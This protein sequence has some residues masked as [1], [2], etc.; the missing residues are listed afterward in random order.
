MNLV[1]SPLDWFILL[2][3][4]LGSL[5]FGM[6]MAYRKNS[7]KDS[8]SFF[9]GGRSIK[10]PVIGASLFA[11][12]IG[13]EH[14]VGLSGDSYRY[15]LSAG[16]VELTTV[17]TL[18]V[19]CAI[20]FPYY[21]KNKLF[22]IPE[23][24][25]LRYNRRTR[26]FFSGLML[27]ISIMTKL[28]FTLFAGALVLNSLLG[29]NIMSTI[30]YIGLAV[31][32]F[33]IIGGFTAVAYTDALQVLII[34]GGAAIMMFIGLDK[35]G[36][37]TGLMEKAPQ[38]MSIAK[39]YDDPVYPFWGILATAFY[40]GIFYWGM[41]QV[42][43]QRTLAA[44]D[45]KNARWGAMFATLLKLLPVFIFALPGVI[46]F[47][48]FPGELQGDETKQTFVLL[49]NKLLPSGLRGLLMA[50]LLAAMI[51]SLIGVLNSV[52]TLVVRDFIVEFKPDFPEKKQVSLGR[53]VILAVTLLG[54]GAAYMVYKNEEGLYKYL[55]TISAY[56]V[57]PVFP[58]ILFGIISKKVTLKG[59]VASV[60]AG[61]I[62]ATIF[63]TD[64]LIGPE[65][66]EQIFPLL[67]HKLTLNFGYRGLWAEILITIVLFAVSAFTEK[68]DP[69]KLEKTTIDYSKGIA[70][71]KG[72]TDWRLH[73][74][75]LTIITVLILIWLK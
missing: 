16:L 36:G 50:S 26:T 13:A 74:L 71:F 14:L 67:H 19:A 6:F 15:G 47:A 46:A 44:P 41:D 69:L 23:F 56:L 7:G 22:T 10:W 2:F 65:T 59:A 31:A 21:M 54:I 70:S 55:Q 33:T 5:G 62:L 43:V 30:F 3:V 39:P 72:L 38:M 37:F 49:L 17:I 52:S 48:L 32:I 29:W 35:V 18:G 61:I 28:A 66:G 11:T 45:L 68:T 34:I 73:L 8:S 24:L 58:A 1:L 27:I 57:I 4:I 20:L 25:E 51:T 42:N 63:V 53:I 40:A 64:Q 60:I 12:N 9:L 75:V